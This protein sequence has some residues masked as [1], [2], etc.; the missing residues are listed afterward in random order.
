M[1]DVDNIDIEL[2]IVLKDDVQTILFEFNTC[3][4]LELSKKTKKEDLKKILLNK[5]IKMLDEDIERIYNDLFKG[6][7]NEIL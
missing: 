3:D 1:D 4:L 2:F 7:I 5:C 6:G